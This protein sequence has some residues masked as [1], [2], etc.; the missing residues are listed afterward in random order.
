[1]VPDEL[2]EDELDE[3]ELLELVVDEVEDAAVDVEVP[4]VPVAEVAALE[5]AVLEAPAVEPPE[6]DDEVDVEVTALGPFDPPPV[7]EAPKA[8]IPV[9]DD[10]LGRFTVPEPPQPARA[11]RATTRGMRNGTSRLTGRRAA[12]RFGAP[13]RRAPM[14]RPA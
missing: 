7:P 11:R 13:R 3:D 10:V 9:V 4:D 6:V 14:V 12:P 8:A 1:M 5:V 2:D